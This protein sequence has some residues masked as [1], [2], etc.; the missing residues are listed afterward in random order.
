MSRSRPVLAVCALLVAVACS[1]CSGGSASTSPS[2]T[3]SGAGSNA[4]S[5]P[6]AV[7]GWGGLS[8][9]ASKLFATSFSKS[10]GVQVSFQD[11]PGGQV[12]AI[13][14]QNAAGQVKWDV[15]D[16][17][18]QDQMLELAQKGLLQKLP[19]Q[20]M[21]KLR[22][23]MPGAVEPWGIKYGTLSNVIACN[24]AIA[25]HCPRTPAQ[26]FDVKGFPGTR[27]LYSYDPLGALTMAAL[28][29]G[30]SPT[31]IFPINIDQAFNTLNRIKPSIKV[32]YQSGD[33]SEQLF[34][35]GEVSMGLLWNGRAYDLQKHPVTHLKL[36]T[37]WDGATY[38]PSVEVAL[39]GAPNL[40][41]AYD[42]LEWIAAHPGIAAKYSDLTTYGFASHAALAKVAPGL[43]KWLPESPANM[44]QQVSPDYSWYVAHLPEIT[45]K[46]N[47]FISG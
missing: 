23:L 26:F 28:A 12:A 22:T 43:R 29:N 11:N 34:R 2:G 35:T 6:L 15:A 19:A 3:G 13:Q 20:V 24:A 44:A 16:A 38:E 37:S 21:T 41:A 25:T 17:L 10:S 31:H 47:D 27:T 7:V 33:Q 14:A 9:Q 30:A 32:F 1:A 42:Y 8:D 5:G 39:K 36:A 40:Q 45:S 4:P 18:S 46:W